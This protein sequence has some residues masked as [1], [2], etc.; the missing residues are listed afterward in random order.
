MTEPA[1]HPRNPDHFFEILSGVSKAKFYTGVF[2]VFS[3]FGVFWAPTEPWYLMAAW[4]AYSGG[5]AASYAYAFSRNY[6]WLFL[7]V[8]LSFIVPT[9]LGYLGG[10]IGADVSTS[11]GWTQPAVMITAILLTVAGYVFFISF[12]R[13][14][15]ARSFRLHTEVSL[16]KRIHTRLVPEVALRVP[17]WEIRGLSIAS[18]EVGGDLLDAIAVEDKI[19]LCVADV[20]GHGVQAGLMM[21]MMKSA[22]RMQMLR[23]LD[24]DR[25]VND[26]NR[27]SFQVKPSEMFMTGAFMRI[28]G[29]SRVGVALAGHPP[30]LHHRRAAKSIT[31]IES[32]FPPLGVLPSVQY[33]SIVVECAPGDT[34]LILTDGLTEVFN[35]QGEE[36]GLERIERILIEQQDRPLDEIQRTILIEVGAFGPQDD[37]QTL[38][39]ARA[40]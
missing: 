19:L 18:S 17:Q 15:G 28:D 26:L 30:I 1:G 3:V 25:L 24:L 10:V 31:R 7:V 14:E 9:G 38:L 29:P 8:P 2:F 39:L 5:I 20:S 35:A 34:F 33:S 37:D 40:T 12:I 11:V 6:R 16:A 23:E 4:V 32:P 13:G 36:F 21:G 27:V 22:A